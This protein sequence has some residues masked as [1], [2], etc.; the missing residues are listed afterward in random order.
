MLVAALLTAC[1][2]GS[3][4][5]APAP[6]LD[7]GNESSSISEAEAI[8]LATDAAADQGLTIDGLE[9]KPSSIFGEWQV[10]FEPVGAD[11]L[12]GGFLVILEAATGDVVDVVQYE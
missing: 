2:G 7:V 12:S 5:P 8:Q 3:D 4:G 1:G 9:A 10:S 6:G 11:G